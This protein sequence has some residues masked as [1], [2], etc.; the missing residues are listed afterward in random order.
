A[1][2]ARILVE[3]HR[4]Y[5]AVIKWIAEGRVELRGRRVIVRI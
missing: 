5:P 4:L 2:A 1:L 3:E